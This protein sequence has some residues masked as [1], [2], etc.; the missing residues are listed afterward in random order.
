L[1]LKSKEYTQLVVELSS[2]GL[3]LFFIY[4]LQEFMV[5]V[6]VAVLPNSLNSVYLFLS[7]FISVNSAFQL[8]SKCKNHS[9]ISHNFL[10][11]SVSSV[12]F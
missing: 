2:K 9:V 11:K 12:L 10:F 4:Q 7:I 3:E 6:N 5:Q 1:F 8:I